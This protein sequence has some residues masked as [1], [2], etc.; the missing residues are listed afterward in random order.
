MGSKES[1]QMENIFE[2]LVGALSEMLG[3]K[4]VSYSSIS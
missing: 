2:G 4:E 3:G 1:A